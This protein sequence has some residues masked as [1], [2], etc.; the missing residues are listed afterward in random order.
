MTP[1]TKLS[2]YGG[3][4]PSRVVRE[5]YLKEHCGLAAGRLEKYR[6][7]RGLP[8]GAPFPEGPDGPHVPSVQAFGDAI[9]A[10]PVM[11]D[12]FDKIFLQVSPLN[13]I[14]NFVTLLF[15]LDLIV[16]QPPRYYVATYPD[17][18]EIG[19][20]VGVPIYLVFDLLSNTSAG[21]DL[22]RMEKFN[23]A[24]KALLDSWGAY[25]AD[26][27]ATPIPS[28][29][30]LNTTP[31]GWFGP[32][33]ITS[34]EA[35]LSPLNFV[36]TFVCPDP[37]A[38]NRGFQT[39]DAFFTRPLQPGVRPVDFR[40]EK[41][42]IHSACEST[43]YKTSENVQLHDQ[44]WLKDQ[45]YSL[46]DMVD[47]HAYAEKFVGGTV[48]QAFL[49]PADYHR[50]HAPV[51]GTV[52]DAFVL[53]GTY[54]A[55]L[56]DSGAE[57]DDPDLNPGDPHGAL[58]RSQ[59]WLTVSS[60]RAVIFIQGDDPIG[61]VCFI[62][63]GMAEVSTCG[64]SVQKGNKVEI[65]DELGM[66]HFGGSSHTLIFRPGIKITWADGVVVDQ[67]QWVNSIIGKAEEVQ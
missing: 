29:D 66:F 18:S 22:F 38:D 12:L 39:W 53:P 34:L 20:P 48:Y 49:S 13:R 28:N 32:A 36:Q 50:W 46:Y 15:V 6:T 10:D 43:V 21:Y 62:G 27:N 7:G 26:P 51:K 16:V 64:L 59:G 41:S 5:A 2:R 37:E 60:T 1:K 57:A 11:K 44:F 33:A 67:H 54:Y 40:E 61:L 4:L 35:H 3:W 25:L 58:I 55:A 56:P 65:G 23:V 63:V 30:S 8:Q 52:L 14:P 17:G 47:G 24:M 45:K 42:L 31:L 19:E 9:N